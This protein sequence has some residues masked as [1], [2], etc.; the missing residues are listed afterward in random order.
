MAKEKGYCRYCGWRWA[1]EGGSGCQECLEK[2]Q[3]KKHLEKRRAERPKTLSI[4][5]INKMAL[6]RGISYGKMVALLETG[7]A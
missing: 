7:K 3:I 2:E 6:E 1:V 4:E 5:E